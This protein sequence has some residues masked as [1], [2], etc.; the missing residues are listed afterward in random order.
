[1]SFD[2]MWK[3]TGKTIGGGGQGQI[4]EVKPSNT[5][6]Y[7]DETY[8]FKQLRNIDSP[9]AV[10]RFKK[11]IEAIRMINDERIVKIIDYSVEDPDH[12]Y[13][14]M[15]NYLTNNYVSL[16]DVVFKDTS[17]FKNNPRLSLEFIKECALAIYQC[18]RNDVIHRD[19]KPKNI[20]FN[21]ES[22]KPLI[23]DFGC[24]QIVDG[25]AVTLIDEGI[26]SKNYMA[27]EC[28][29]G[30]IGKSNDR[31]DVYSL[32]KILWVLITG[33][34]TFSREK[35]V[36]TNRSL[37][38]IY[39]HNPECWH[40]NRIFEFSVRSKIEDRQDASSI[41]GL[42]DLLIR[43]ILGKYPPLEHVRQI[44]PS[45]GQG[46]LYEE[47]DNYVVPM[48]ALFTNPMPDG[49]KGYVCNICGYICARDDR[50]LNDY[51]NKRRA[52]D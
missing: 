20:L 28:E 30:S 51:I 2:A 22:L 5:D 35:P 29:S 52:F 24:C 11:E 9:Q 34:Q 15:P 21:N 42:C 19:L 37:N 14:V 46:N 26:G 39:P 38:N 49:I 13:Y 27:P 40:L 41:A 32:G 50:I 33:Q 18:H 6:R 44:C 4:F 23:I 1:M 31:S 12:I 7:N 16:E 48:H 36:F 17:P 25:E 8:A 3:K 43:N 47:L 10:Q 45:C